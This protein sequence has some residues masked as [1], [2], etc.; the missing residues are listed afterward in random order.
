[1]TQEFRKDV[2]NIQKRL[3]ALSMELKELGVWRESGIVREHIDRACTEVGSLHTDM[4]AIERDV[5]KLRDDVAKIR[6]RAIDGVVTIQDDLVDAR[7][8][9]VAIRCRVY[10]ICELVQAGEKILALAEASLNPYH[11]E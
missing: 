7:R 11:D 10:E 9:F 5:A 4:Q 2:T 3:V 1:M 8:R 6:G